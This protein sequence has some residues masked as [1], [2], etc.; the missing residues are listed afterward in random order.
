MATSETE[1][2]EQ[3]QQRLLHELDVNELHHDFEQYAAQTLTK[4]ELFAIL[5][6]KYGVQID[7]EQLELIFK[8]IDSR[9]DDRSSWEEFITYLIA[10]FESSDPQ[11]AA[12]DLS[13]IQPIANAPPRQCPSRHMLPINR[14]RYSCAASA[15]QKGGGI[16]LT[17]SRDGT[18]NMWNADFQ[19]LLQTHKSKSPTLQ[20]NKT[21]ILDFIYMADVQM[22]CT[23]SI[24]C[25][26]RFYDM[27]ANSFQ[28]QLIISGVPS[29]VCAMNCGRAV[30]AANDDGKVASS[31]IVMG[32]AAGNVILFSFD[33]SER[34]VF[35]NNTSHEY[36]SVTWSD[37]TKRG[38]LPAIAVRQ[39]ASIHADEV[40]QIEY[41][42]SLDAI[43][44]AS[45]ANIVWKNHRTAGLSVIKMG[46]AESKT[47]I[48]VPKGVQC[49]D[50]VGNDSENGNEAV[51]LVVT[52]GAD[53]NVR[54]WN[55]TVPEKPMALFTGHQ[56]G[57]TFVCAQDN[58]QRIYS[59]DKCK[60]V[61]VW[62]V[63]K[64]T[65]IQT[66]NMFA[67]SI[68]DRCSLTAIYTDA[69]RR[70]IVGG[71]QISMVQC[72]PLLDT[73]IS[74]GTTHQMCVSRILYNSLFDTMITCS[75]DS[76]IVNWSMALGGKR[77]KFIRG[78]H[79]ITVYGEV[80]MLPI[81]AATFN[82]NQHYLITGAS[83]GT[84]KVWDF[85]RGICLRNLSIDVVK[86]VY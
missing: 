24:E 5:Q 4:H 75:F 19:Q 65:I 84:I 59:L 2:I 27:R 46:A 10:I 11:N 62:N 69:Q 82:P 15:Q 23:A 71:M 64:A 67:T 48:A 77:L 6:R 35:E 31:R 41:C 73:N 3:I 83:N 1:T 60:I 42:P 20:I 28:L 33:C 63:T 70:L 38:R 44:S 52:G 13:A 86:E 7:S 57:I 81:S 12:D 14:I 25:D 39:F 8:R 85:N 76:S 68:S 16:Y 53:T 29:A 32:D 74:D 37:M 72:S 45:N 21:W 51:T 9:G 54:L 78:A 47:L 66:Y 43:L 36:M 34:N 56:A 61:K 49:F 40:T 18:I 26:L 30:V 22:V 17:S 80:L 79:T 50:I 55:I 58:C